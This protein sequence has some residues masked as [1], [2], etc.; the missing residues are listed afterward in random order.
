MPKALVPPGVISADAP[1]R[2][3]K[4]DIA[5]GNGKCSSVPPIGLKRGGAGLR[6]TIN[7]PGLAAQPSGWLLVWAIDREAEGCIAT[8]QGIK[9]AQALAESA[10]L[11]AGLA[12]RLLHEPFI[13]DKP[14]FADLGTENR[15]QVDS[16]ISRDSAPADVT[17]LDTKVSQGA[18]PGVLNVEIK[19][20]P[21]VVGYE[22]A[23]YAL[24][25]KANGMGSSIV[26][27]YAESHIAGAISRDASPRVNPFHFRPDAAFYR[28]F[29]RGDRTII[30][31]AGA[32]PVELQK[33]TNAL[34]GNPAACD[35]FP[36]GSC[37]LLPTSMGANRHVLVKVNGEEIA[38]LWGATVRSAIVAAKA[39]P[40][41]VLP[42]LAVRK[43]YAN[44]IAPVEFSNGTPDILSL[45]L[46]G[47]E[48]ISWQ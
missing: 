36:A 20:S 47:G 19:T 18:N 34:R 15:I 6:A 35:G 28:M 9:L 41:D 46:A 25:P 13:A 44:R 11:S 1:Q 14:S 10:P 37:V 26:P 8:G 29:Y 30:V 4:L 2:I 43:P 42:K 38:L 21:T 5:A 24:T 32:T 31:V 45:P 7:V 12:I 33:E 22:T 23:W 17:P 40:E 3:V 39:R 27:L 48:E 16:P